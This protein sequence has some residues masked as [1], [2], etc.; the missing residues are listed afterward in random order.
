MKKTKQYQ[1]GKH[2]Y[3]KSGNK[4]EVHTVKEKKPLEMEF[5]KNYQEVYVD[6]FQFENTKEGM[7]IFFGKKIFGT[8][9]I[10]RKRTILLQKGTAGKTIKLLED[11]LE[12]IDSEK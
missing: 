1:K 3:I 10:K 2:L 5:D 6:E 4:K 9:K 8:D 12:K 7:K 11:V